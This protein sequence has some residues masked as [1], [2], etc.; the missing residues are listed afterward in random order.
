MHVP[1]VTNATR[2]DEELIV[3][4]EFVELEND[5]VPFP[6]SAEAVDEMVGGVSS[7]V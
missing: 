5:F 2:P 1:V 7:S 3:H 6:S 4:T